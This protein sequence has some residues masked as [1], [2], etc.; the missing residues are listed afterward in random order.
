VGGDPG[1]RQAGVPAV[2]DGTIDWRLPAHRREAFQRFYS[3]HLQ[4]RTHPGCVY[5]WLPAIADELDLDAD[6]RAW[7]VWLN[8]NTQNPV[9]SLMLLEEAPSH[10]DAEKAIAFWN[11]HFKQLEWDT[12]RRHQK[13]RFDVATRRWVEMVGDHPARQWER[14][15]LLGWDDTWAYARSHPYM[16]R[17]SAWSMT[18]YARILFGDDVPDA[19]D[20]L[21]GDLKGSNSHRNGLMVVAGEDA[22]YW[23]PED[24]A[25]YPSVSWM[26]AWAEELLAEARARAAGQPWEHDVTRLTME[27]ALCT[28][29]SWHKPNRRY[30]NVYADM[31]YYR[32]LRA[33]RHFG[34]RFDLLWDARARQ[35]PEALRL[36]CNLHDPG[37]APVKQNWYRETGEIILLHLTNPDMSESGFDELVRTRHFKIREDS[38][39]WS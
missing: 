17:L 39:R 24:V 19:G 7:L 37:L 33:E 2:T 11:T 35:L 5:F 12:D 31:A 21:L 18:E 6:Q 14:V 16:G 25:L 15:G 22:T 38:D 13:S 34:R 27:S 32:L 8:G 1:G 29:K 30:P 9:T 4:F 20:F 28:Y 3:F 23:E 10:R 36:E 26:E